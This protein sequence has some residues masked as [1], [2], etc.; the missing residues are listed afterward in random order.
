M[1]NSEASKY[2][3]LLFQVSFDPSRVLLLPLQCIGIVSILQID[4][5]SDSHLYL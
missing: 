4:T 3:A 1:N 2:G 5:V